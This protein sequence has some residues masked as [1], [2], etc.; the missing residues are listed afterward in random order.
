MVFE[1][2]YEANEPKYRRNIKSANDKVSNIL[3]TL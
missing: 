1:H 3:W 2:C